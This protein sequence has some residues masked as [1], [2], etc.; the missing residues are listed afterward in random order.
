M[1][2]KCEREDERRREQKGQGWK[3]SGWMDE[4]SRCGRQ[5]FVV[6]AFFSKIFRLRLFWRTV[7][8][9][10]P[11]VCA[12]SAISG[13]NFSFSPFVR[14]S[15]SL[16]SSC[17]EPCF[18]F[19]LATSHIFFLYFSGSLPLSLPLLLFFF[20]R[21][22]FSS[23]SLIFESRATNKSIFYL[24]KIRFFVIYFGII[25]LQWKKYINVNF[26]PLRRK[27]ISLI[28][29]FMQKWVC[30]LHVLE[31]SEREREGK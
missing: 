3:P 17:T 5:H 4:Q 20:H 23:F 2:K 27:R 21:I 12:S 6:L 24:P 8:A 28:N 16:T 22:C 31:E 19:F 7:C 14:S 11:C 25:N 30:V 29:V 26:R 18:S 10:T 15:A 1:E 13:F 9:R